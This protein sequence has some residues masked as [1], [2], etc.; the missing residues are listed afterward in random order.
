MLEIALAQEWALSLRSHSFAMRNGRVGTTFE[1][2][3]DAVLVKIFALLSSSQI[4]SSCAL[5]CRAWRD[6]TC[7]ATLWSE[8][9]EGS[10]LRGNDAMQCLG[11]WKGLFG[12]VYGVN[13]IASPY[14]ERIHYLDADRLKHQFLRPWEPKHRFIIDR[15]CRTDECDEEP[16]FYG[17][18]ATEGGSV[19]QRGGGDGVLRECPA[20]DCS[21][22]P[23]AVDKLLMATSWH[24]GKVQQ[25]VGLQTFSNKFLNCSPPMM[26]SIWYAGRKGDP[27][28]FKCQVVIRDE[29]KNVIFSWYVFVCGFCQFIWP[30][31]DG[32]FLGWS[33]ALSSMQALPTM[34]MNEFGR[35][36]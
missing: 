3:P 25:Y 15:I 14:F 16:H 17:Y 5:V 33:G 1:S 2:I 30:F 4:A 10:G 22:C 20:S 24:W 35:A 31:C 13:L 28:V 32:L 21:P 34:I 23:V 29:L 27:S 11:G 9:C 26:F 36:C 8:L 6:S 7:D 12:S 19:F 18:W